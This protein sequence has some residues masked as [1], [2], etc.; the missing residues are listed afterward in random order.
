MFLRKID[1]MKIR[2]KLKFGYSLVIGLMVVIAVFS[3]IGL[4][5]VQGKMNDYIN[6]AQAADTAVKQCRINMNA[7]A[8][9]IREMTLNANRNTY[10]DYRNKVEECAQVMGESIEEL[11]EAK[12]V[13]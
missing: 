6:G 3:I 1:G 12:V 9:N 7:A 11:K 4:F 5:F 2:E 8:R 13:N 10:E